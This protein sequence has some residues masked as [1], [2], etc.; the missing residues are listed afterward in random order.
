MIDTSPAVLDP[1]STAAKEIT[2]LW[3]DITAHVRNYRKE[4]DYGTEACRILEPHPARP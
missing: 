4:E 1:Q 3:Q 2:A